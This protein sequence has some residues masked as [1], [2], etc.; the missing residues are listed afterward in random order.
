M[1]FGIS[2]F[3]DG[4][5]WWK[6]RGSNGDGTWQG[7]NIDKELSDGGLQRI[8]KVKVHPGY[9]GVTTRNGLIY[10]MDRP[11]KE[12]FERLS[13]YFASTHKRKGFSGN[14]LTSPNTK[15]LDMGKVQDLRLPFTR[16]KPIA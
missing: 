4:E 10:L 12:K 6:W 15:S 7:P 9:S 8:W 2:A 14:I 13:G 5:D 1:V 11:P 3:G 16:E